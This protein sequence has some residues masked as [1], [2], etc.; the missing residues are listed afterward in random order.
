MIKAVPRLFCDRGAWLAVASLALASCYGP[1][2]MQ[3]VSEEICRF[4]ES[5]SRLDQ[6]LTCVLERLRISHEPKDTR[7]VMGRLADLWEE[8]DGAFAFDISDALLYA[9]QAHPE[10][11]FDM[12]ASHQAGFEEW[13]ASLGALS[14]TWYAEP[15]SPLHERRQEVLEALASFA[16][17][18]RIRVRLA[19]QALGSIQAITPERVD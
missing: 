13:L 9:M 7:N 4:P 18:E 17:R 11:F 16:E 3:T 10:E 15:P 12:A 2:P 5:E 1:I 8:R 6:E 14:F 19:E